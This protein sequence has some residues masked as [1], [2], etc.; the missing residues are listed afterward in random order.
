[1]TIFFNYLRELKPLLLNGFAMYTT[2]SNRTL[3]LVAKRPDFLLPFRQKAPTIERALG[4]IYSD[5]DHLLTPEGFWNILMFRGITYGS[6]YAKDDLEWVNSD[7]EW[8][9]Y[10]K[11]SKKTLKGNKERYFV[12]VCAYGFNNKWRTMDNASS[13]WAERHSWTS[14]IQKQPKV[15]ELY[16]FL[17]GKRVRKAI[18]PN[19]G[20]LS[21]LLICGDL[22]EAGILDMPTIEEWASLIYTVQKGATYGL[23]C[24]ALLGETFSKE[25]VIDA[26]KTLDTFVLETLTDEDCELMGYNIIMLEH[27][28]C[29]FTRILPKADKPAKT[30]RPKKPSK[31]ALGKE[32]LRAM[33]TEEDM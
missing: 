25:E 7:T 21:A 10:Y 9:K 32:K 8:Q 33:A 26:F 14:F 29:K 22:V 2:S 13:Y 3:R 6:L 11:T 18:F 5:V 4:T 16:K 1:M 27:S 17:T 30:S 19:I 28:L 31:K 23:Q 20:G 24:L 12:N 15:E